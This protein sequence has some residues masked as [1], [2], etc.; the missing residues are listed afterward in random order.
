MLADDKER[1]EHTMLVDL[2][3]NDVRRVSEPGSVR[4]EEFMNVPS[5]ATSST[6]NR[7]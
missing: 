5:T 7:P 3:R 1:A 4:V 2:A 6:S